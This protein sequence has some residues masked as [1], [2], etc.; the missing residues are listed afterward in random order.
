MSGGY[1]TS[2]LDNVRKSIEVSKI[3]TLFRPAAENCDE[4]VNGSHIDYRD[5]FYLATLGGARVMG[6]DNKIGESLL[7][8]IAI[9]SRENILMRCL[10]FSDFTRLILN[11]G[12]AKVDIGGR[13]MYFL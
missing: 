11:K 10:E 8:H 13:V 6:L 1:S 9:A 3:L 5:A 4:P 7:R 2:V 12:L